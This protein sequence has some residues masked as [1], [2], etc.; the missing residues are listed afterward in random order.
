[1]TEHIGLPDN[2]LIQLEQVLPPRRHIICHVFSRTL[3][4]Q[5][6]GMN[7]YIFY[8]TAFIR[9]MLTNKSLLFSIHLFLLTTHPFFSAL[10]RCISFGTPIS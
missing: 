2:A 10:N 5:K 1:L 4:W 7:L 6:N 3:D 9:S 8:S